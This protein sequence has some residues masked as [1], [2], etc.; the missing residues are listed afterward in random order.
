MTGTVHPGP[1]AT[2]DRQGISEEKF[3]VK[4]PPRPAELFAAFDGPDLIA[5]AGFIPTI[6]SKYRQA[7]A[8]QTAEATIRKEAVAKIRPAGLINDVPEKVVAAGLEHERCR[9]GGAAAATAAAGRARRRRHDA[10]R[11]VEAGRRFGPPEGNDPKLD[12]GF[13]LAREGDP[14]V[15][16]LERAARCR[17]RPR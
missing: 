12:V 16:G 10:V 4:I 15:V 1:A 3:Q 17:R 8:R 6:R 13:T 2:L 14:N 11:P 9:A 7:R 5:Y